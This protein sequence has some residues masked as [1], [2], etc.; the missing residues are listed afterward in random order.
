MERSR[1]TLNQRISRFV[2]FKNGIV[3]RHHWLEGDNSG[4]L[5]PDGV[6]LNE[7][8][9]DIFLNGIREDTRRVHRTSKENTKCK[10]G[11]TLQRDTAESRRLNTSSGTGTPERSLRPHSYTWSCTLR[12]GVPVPE[13]GFNQRDSAVSH[14]SVTP[15]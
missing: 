5:L 13:L 15:A 6:H 12:F 9:I 10:A 3:V 4:F 7:A 11:V 2:R 1:R 14:C 8:G